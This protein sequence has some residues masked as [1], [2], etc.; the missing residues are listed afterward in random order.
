MNQPFSGSKWVE[1]NLDAVEHNYVQI[2]EFVPADV[3]IL[4]VVK[5]DAYGHGAVEVSRI[6][7]QAE[8]D[9]LGVTTIEEGLELRRNDIKTPILVFGPFLPEDIDIIL[10]HDLTV[11]VAS[12]EAIQWLRNAVENSGQTIKVHLKVETGMGRLGFWPQDVVEAAQ[13]IAAVP[14][15]V[16]EGVYSHFAAAMWKD[17][18]YTRKQFQIF[19]KTLAALEKAGFT[20]LIR[21]IANSAA[22]LDLPE[23]HLDMVRTGNLLYGQYSSPWQEGRL[24]LQNTWSMK[25]RVLYLREVPPGHSIGYGCTYKTKGRAKI[26]ILPVGFSDGFQVE[27]EFR[28]TNLKD[29]IKN[30]LKVM[31]RFLDHPRLRTVISFPQ[32]KG[33]I[34]GKT[35]MQLTMVDVTGVREIKRG[36][37]AEIPAR[38]TSISGRV[39]HVYLYHQQVTGVRKAGEVLVEHGFAAK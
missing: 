3:K 7:E 30:I 18:A 23:M 6:L 21:H 15:L 32:G 14:G 11:T 13:E 35:G 33:Y 38:R 19:T 34:V 31:L 4:G 22:L 5:A 16:L 27:P 17:K 36:D 28:P 12:K 10:Y 25:T 8:V 1:V 24:A 26:A 9:M 39:P 20:G 29:L 2:R 37:V